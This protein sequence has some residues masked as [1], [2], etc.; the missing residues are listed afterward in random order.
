V[1]ELFVHSS[2]LTEKLPALKLLVR[3]VERVKAVFYLYPQSHQ[4]YETKH[5]RMFAVITFVLLS[6][7]RLSLT[8][9]LSTKVLLYREAVLSPSRT[10]AQPR[11]CNDNHEAH[12]MLQN[13]AYHYAPGITH[14]QA[15]ICDV[16][17]SVLALSLLQMG[18]VLW[19][20]HHS[21]CPLLMMFSL[22]LV[23]TDGRVGS[24]QVALGSP[25]FMPT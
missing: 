15:H 16:S 23:F 14:S 21:H 18:K 13:T 12:N 19:G 8:I 11:R 22:T 1:K 10:I 7:F 4:A 5:G 6:L 2:T 9:P 20:R 3:R 25:V 17:F 24:V